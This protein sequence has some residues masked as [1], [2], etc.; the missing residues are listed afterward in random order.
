MSIASLST[1]STKANLRSFSD[2]LYKSFLSSNGSAPI[3]DRE[4]K[5]T[6]LIMHSWELVNAAAWRHYLW[7]T[8][9]GEGVKCQHVV[10]M[11]LVGAQMLRAAGEEGAE[12]D[13]DALREHD[14]C[15]FLKGE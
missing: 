14:W 10:D 2:S 9:P 7:C 3:H 15:T 11:I 6:L 4:F 8:C 5:R 12:V 13:W 1:Q